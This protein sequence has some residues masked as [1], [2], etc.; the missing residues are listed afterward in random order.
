M[1]VLLLVAGSLYLSYVFSFLYLWTVSP[2]VFPAPGQEAL[3]SAGWPFATGALLLISSGLIALCGRL[4]SRRRVSWL[5]LA[6]LLL[7][8]T[9]ALSASLFTEILAH[10]WTGLRPH[11][12]SYAAMVYTGSFLQAELVLPLLVFV[13]FVLARLFTGRLDRERRVTFDNLALFWHYT[14][15]QGLVTL[16]L[17]HGFPRLIA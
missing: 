13:G 10:W 6:S 9:G 15:G 8:A 3:P 2:Q 16:A 1:V 12:T 7:L 4:L 5:A 11:D 17:L 14:V